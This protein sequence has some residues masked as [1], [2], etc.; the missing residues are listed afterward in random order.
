[1][2]GITTIHGVGGV[3]L[4]LSR[5][6]DALGGRSRPTT[7]GNRGASFQ[8]TVDALNNLGA[9]VVGLGTN[10]QPDY[11]P[12]QTL[13]S[14]AI[15]TGAVNGSTQTIDGGISVD[16]IAPGDPLYFFIN[17]FL[18]ASI[19]NG[20]VAAVTSAAKD[21]AFD[22]DVVPSDPSVSFANLTGVVRGVG[23]NR[24]VS[25]DTRITGD[26]QAHSF[27]LNFVRAGTGVLLG[28]IPVTI[29]N[30]FL[31]SAQALDPDGDPVTYS[32][33][34]GPAG[35]AVHPHRGRLDGDPAAAG[36]YAFRLRAEDGRGGVAFQDFAVTVTS[37]QADQAPTI[38]SVAPAHATAALPFSYR[39]TATDPDGDALSY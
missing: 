13:E 39:V 10:D 7:P 14:L 27:D 5:L 32:L 25:F 23:P 22:I 19:A 36:S 28:S 34:S 38:T 12:R 16:P 33:V 21:T 8:P 4:P 2:D 6:T 30:D 37:G 35:A 29:N 15:L 17:Q 11:A 20:V 1:P 31:Y 26:G 9:L 24:T 18:P 3:P